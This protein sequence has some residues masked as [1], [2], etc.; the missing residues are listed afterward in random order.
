MLAEWRL[1]L[2][3]TDRDFFE[4]TDSWSQMTADFGAAV[5]SAWQPRKLALHGPIV[6]LT[7]VWMHPDHAQRSLWADAVRALIQR[8]YAKR[9][10]ALFLTTWPADY[11]TE[12]AERLD[13]RGHDRWDQRRTSLGRLACQ[14]LGVRPFPAGCLEEDRWWFWLPLQEGVPRPRKRRPR[15]S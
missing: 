1:P 5:L 8:R 2:W 12:E 13:W 3:V 15:Y 9:F 11:K 6:E 14:K 4:A 10:A 7:R